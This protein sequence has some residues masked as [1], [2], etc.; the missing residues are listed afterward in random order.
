MEAEEWQ[1]RN[2]KHYA[3]KSKSTFSMCETEHGSPENGGL[4]KVEYIFCLD[5]FFCSNSHLCFLYINMFCIKSWSQNGKC[6][7]K[8]CLMIPISALIYESMSLP[9]SW[10]VFMAGRME[11]TT[12][13]VMQW[14]LVEV[15]EAVGTCRTTWV[16]KGMTP[17][18]ENYGTQSLEIYRTFPTVLKEILGYCDSLDLQW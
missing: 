18:W 10:V 1:S 13:A 17:P 9:T 2:Q 11:V 8:G 4:M 6:F 15:S 7:W 16:W 5:I 3:S 14:P 12:V